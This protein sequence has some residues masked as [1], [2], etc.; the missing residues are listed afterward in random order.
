MQEKPQRTQR[1]DA[2]LR[3]G[4]FF[5]AELCENLASFAIKYLVFDELAWANAKL[6]ALS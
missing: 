5:F 1:K 6:N 4:K 3:K 2:K